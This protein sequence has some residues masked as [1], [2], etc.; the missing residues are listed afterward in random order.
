MSL[1]VKYIMDH[2]M[3]P[4]DTFDFKCK[5][6][7]RCCHYRE[8]LLLTGVDVFRIAKY[9]CKLP[10]EII[11]ENCEVYIGDTSRIPVVRVVPKNYDLVCPFLINNKCSVHKAKPIVCAVFPLARCHLKTGEVFYVLPEGTPDCGEKGELH[12]VRDWLSSFGIPVD[13]PEGKLWSEA[14][15]CC[16]AYMYEKKS[17]KYSRRRQLGNEM[18]RLLFL[19]Y[20]INMEFLPQLS[21]NFEQIKALM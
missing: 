5:K 19:N 2:K 8:D 4:D 13:D 21:A 9:L 18:L 3:G 10:V 6:C 16:S 1:D 15:A 7:G 20:N 14:V 12:T 17:M 11:K